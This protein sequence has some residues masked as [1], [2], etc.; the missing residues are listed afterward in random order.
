MLE[1]DYLALFHGHQ[2]IPKLKAELAIAEQEIDTCTDGLTLATERGDYWHTVYVKQVETS[3]KN[4]I[5]AHVPWVLL[6]LESGVL[7]ALAIRGGAK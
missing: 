3:R 6:V 1:L 2:V 7:A 5:W 4:R